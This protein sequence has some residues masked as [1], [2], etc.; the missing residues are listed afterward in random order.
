MYPIAKRLFD[1]AVAITGLLLLSPLLLAVTICV[2][3]KL[4]GPVLF[5]QKRPGLDGELFSLYKFR[6]MLDRRG[7]DGEPLPDE[8]RLTPFGAFLRKTSLDE[9]PELWNV[10]KGD[11]SLV[12]PRP[13]L[14]EYLD[15]YSQ[16]QHRRHEVRPGL[17]GWAQ[18]NG[19][20]TVEWE[21]RL[22]MDVWYVDNCTFLLDLK[23]LWRTLL[24]VLRSD[25]INQDGQVTM[26]KFRG[27]GK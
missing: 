9:L 7:P 26:T 18:V 25:G 24:V 22:A 2:R 4:G 16:E 10:I 6:T 8:E 3:W 11:M 5:Q 23:I 1:L 19:R 17:T 13:L 20:N 15:Y 14:S 12:G 21:E 27:S